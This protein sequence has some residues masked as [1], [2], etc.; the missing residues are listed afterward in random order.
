MDVPPETSHQIVSRELTLQK[1]ELA[2]ALAV[3]FLAVGKNGF[4]GGGKGIIWALVSLLAPPDQHIL[5]SEVAKDWLQ[6]FPFAR[7]GSCWNLLPYAK[8]LQ[9]PRRGAFGEAGKEQATTTLPFRCCC[10]S[11]CS[12]H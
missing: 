2:R 6:S 4:S 11:A 12:V 3:P 10:A 5:L 1:R 9:I 8:A 7:S